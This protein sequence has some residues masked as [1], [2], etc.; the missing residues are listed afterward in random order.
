MPWENCRAA[1][2][3]DSSHMCCVELSLKAVL[4]LASAVKSLW[5]TG[6]FPVHWP[7]GYAMLIS[8][9]KGETAVHGCH[10]PGDM[11]VRMREALARPWVGVCVLLQLFFVFS[12]ISNLG[13]LET[14]MKTISKWNTM[15]TFTQAPLW[16]SYD[17]RYNNQGLQTKQLC[18]ST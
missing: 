3:P 13:E 17:G 9:N 12:S 10:C 5:Y 16:L 7:D 4:A 6:I 8:P 1:L 11:A 15:T 14:V 2:S 18:N